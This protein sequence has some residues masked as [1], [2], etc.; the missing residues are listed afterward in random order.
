VA[1]A[2]LTIDAT[3]AIVLSLPADTDA[4]R[5]LIWQTADPAVDLQDLRLFLK[6]TG[7]SYEQAADIFATRF[8]NP[9]KR[10]VL[11]MDLRDLENATLKLKPEDNDGLLARRHEHLWK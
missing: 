7:L 2:R 8:V 11:P 10:T 5:L 4:K 3:E 1:V 6:R 9:Q